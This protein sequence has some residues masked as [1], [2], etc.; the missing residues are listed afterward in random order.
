MKRLLVLDPF[1]SFSLVP[2]FKKR[3]DDVWEMANLDTE[4]MLDICRNVRADV[5]F[6]DFCNEN[7]VNLTNKILTMHS[8]PKVV[9]RLHGY[10]AQ[11]WYMNSIDWSFVSD[12]IVVSPKFKEI[13]EEKLNHTSYRPKIH[14]IPNGIDLD[15]FQLQTDFDDN[16][17][18][19]AGYFNKKKGPTLLRTVMASMPH[20][21]FHLAG[22]H[23][24]PQVQLYFEDLRLD[25]VSYYGWVQ[26]EEFLKGKR[27]ILSTSV[28]ESFGMSI[29]EGM[30]MGLTPLV[31]AWPGADKVW[32][33]G[34]LWK[35]FSDLEILATNPLNPKQCR[36]W[37]V[38]RYSMDN[39]IEKIWRL[40][41]L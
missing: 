8:Q 14:V 34:C 28:T 40:F 3:F 24:D 29:G 36:Q 16:A 19:Y 23:Q 9:I 32:P 7:A 15:K 11:S 39:C 12:L 17:I 30:A 41:E 1:K 2:Y 6:V 13:A 37:I 27:F 38:D 21:D 5:I 4:H 33:Q 25:N 22:T 26:T 18:A 35:S 10:E 20:M 31:H